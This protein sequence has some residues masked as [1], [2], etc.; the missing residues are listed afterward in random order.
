M[1]ALFFKEQKKEKDNPL[2][3]NNNN[4]S[5]IINMRS[6]GSDVRTRPG[7]SKM[8]TAKSSRKNMIFSDS[9][10]ITKPVVNYN[11]FFM[12]YHLHAIRTRSLII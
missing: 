4:N 6:I 3:N 1:N 10:I 2:S 5:S 8:L 9:T 11:G 7:S 12:L